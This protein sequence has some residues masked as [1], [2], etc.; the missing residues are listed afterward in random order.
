M[1]R[2]KKGAL[3]PADE[4]SLDSNSAFE[5]QEPAVRT[6]AGPGDQKPDTQLTTRCLENRG[7]RSV[8]CEV[9]MKW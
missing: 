8:R 9:M 2:R 4:G 7:R 6:S 5:E 1:R 3:V